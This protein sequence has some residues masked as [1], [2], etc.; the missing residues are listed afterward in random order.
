[1][2]IKRKDIL[3]L[4]AMPLLASCDSFLD[5]VPEKDIT[6]IESVFEQRTQVDEWEADCYSF[7]TYL[8]TPQGNIGLTASDE[9][10]G[11]QYLRSN[12]QYPFEGL[13]IGDGVQSVQAP[14]NDVWR[15]NQ[16]FSAIRYCNTFL[17][18][19]PDCFNMTDLE[20]KQW[21][22]EV[23]ALKAFLY[24]EMVRMYGPIILVPENIPVESDVEV[25]KQ[26]RR[27]I[28]ECFKAIVTLLDEALAD[29]LQS[30]SQKSKSHSAYFSRES[31]LA[32]KAKVL[33]YEASP[34]YNGNKT[35]SHFKN[36]LGEQLFPQTYDETKWKK[37]AEA[38]DEAVKECEAA[39]Y[40]LV[41]GSVSK[42]TQLLN[43]MADCEKRVQSPAYNNSE[44]IFYVKY[45]NT[46]MYWAEKIYTYILPRLQSTDY[47][48]YNALAYG[49]LSPTIKM[50]EMYYTDRGLPI[51]EDPNWD[52]SSR[53]RGMSRE[54]DAATYDKVVPE[55]VKV[56]NLHLRRE[57]RFY[58]DIAA[59]RCLWQRGPE[60]EQPWDPDYNLFV[61]AYKG[62]SFGT[63]ANSIQQDIPQNLSGY[64]LKKYLYS[65]IN[66][67]SYS[68]DY[69]A[70]GEDPFAYMRL[71]ELYL[72]QA[73]AWNEAEGPSQ[74]VYDALDKVRRRAGI[75]GVQEAWARAYHPEKINTQD[76]LRGIIKQETNIE[77][78]FEGHR[79]WNLRRWNEAQVL[80][81]PLM[82]W[83]IA[84]DN[85][86][87]FYN[88]WQGPVTVWAKRKF[89]FPRDYLWPIKSEEVMISGVVQNPGW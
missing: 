67:R 59:D 32:L 53:Y 81:E 27:P 74:K 14:Y 28:D 62:E 42:S 89:T 83:N 5:L 3:L 51:D 38:C 19:T 86:D 23:K 46:Y 71:S 31:A 55:N 4:A 44:G 24:F 33:V 61:K 45:P 12:I 2:K 48:N 16:Y 73:E 41:S 34:F 82:G 80:G 88:N 43:T 52:Y 21:M 11:N 69:S 65:T 77:L 54:S 57:P 20:K 35:Y 29:G 1:M 26:P 66:T 68:D 37:A 8:A 78:A 15:G 64:W 47:E 22:A 39:G 70:T 10:V 49:S 7:I 76:G 84:A 79:F 18:H 17:K 63:Q 87:G 58:A 30:K 60:Q 72:M 50:V 85:V 75:P 25:M 13:Y 40:R 6:T 9:L 56:L 36:K